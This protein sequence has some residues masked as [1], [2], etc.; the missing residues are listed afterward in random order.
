VQVGRWGSIKKVAA[1]ADGSLWLSYK[2]GLLERYSEG[3]KLLWSSNSGSAATFLQGQGLPGASG[4]TGGAGFKP[5]G[6][7]QQRNRPI[8]LCQRCSMLR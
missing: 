8:I 1:A 5:A 4:S 7:M 6:I 3:G 2:R